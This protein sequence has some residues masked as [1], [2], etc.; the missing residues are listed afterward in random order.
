MQSLE[1][2]IPPPIVMTV[3]AAV[4]W[5]IKSLPP[6]LPLPAL[7]QMS[8]ALVIL[9]IGLGFS[10]A[11]VAAFRRADTT[12]NPLK[13]ETTSS[14]VSTGVYR[15]TRNPMYVG[16]FL[17]LVAWAIYLSSAWTWFGPVGLCLYLTQFQIK[18]EERAMAKLFGKE[19]EAYR[20]RVRRWL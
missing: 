9:S 6:M 16:M 14:L 15:I 7:I 1:L 18:P 19:F 20:T 8:I 17:V 2:K 13:P 11:G 5:M 10:V 3:F 4:M 12:V